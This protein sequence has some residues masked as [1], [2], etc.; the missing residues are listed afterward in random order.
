M[1]NVLRGLGFAREDEARHCHEFSG[2]WQMRIALVRLLLIGP[3]LESILMRR[4]GADWAPI[5]PTIRACSLLLVSHDEELLYALPPASTRC[6]TAIW[7]STSRA[8][9]RSG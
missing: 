1:S 8:V 2:G 7:S 5:W 4:R 6:A 9:T 3:L